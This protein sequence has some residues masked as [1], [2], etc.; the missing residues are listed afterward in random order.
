MSLPKKLC[1]GIRYLAS[2]AF[3]NFLTFQN[4]TTGQTAGVPNA[5]SIVA[6]NVYANVTAWRSKEVEKAQNRIGQ[7]IY[8]AVIHYPQTYVVNSGMQIVWNGNTG[9]IDSFYDPDGQQVEL[10]IYF[11]INNAVYGTAS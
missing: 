2:G 3:N 1:T 10:H 11:W 6:S 7:S 9:E 8:K 4:P 5:P